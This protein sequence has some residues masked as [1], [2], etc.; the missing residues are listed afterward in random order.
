MK[1]L[2]IHKKILIYLNP[3]INLRC[4]AVFENGKF[5][6][7][8]SAV[9]NSNGNNQVLSFGPDVLKAI[10]TLPPASVNTT[11]T[12]TK[13]SFISEHLRNENAESWIDRNEDRIVPPGFT[14]DQII[15]EWDI[16]HDSIYSATV[17]KEA[18]E[19]YRK[20][21]SNSRLMFNS[22]TIPLWDL[23]ILYSSY[24]RSSFV[25][26][27]VTED[28]SILGYIRDGKLQKLAHFWTDYQDLHKEP[29]E[30]GEELSLLI[31]SLTEGDTIS[32]VIPLII[33]EKPTLPNEFIIPEYIIS[34]PPNINTIPLQYHEPYACSLHTQTQLDFANITDTQK[35]QKVEKNRRKY[36]T[37][38]RGSFIIIVTFVLLLLIS[39]G[40]ITGIEKYADKRIRPYQ[41][42][43]D[44]IEAGERKL[45]SL[46]RTYK[47][48]AIFFTRESI[49]TFLLN[50]LQ[51]IFPDGVWA[52]QI[53]ISEN[54]EKLWRVNI[55]A[56]SY[57]TA[58][59]PQFLNKLEQIEGTDKVRM[60][61]SEQI[62]TE[63]NKRA[64]KI[65]VECLW[66]LGG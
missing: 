33:H 66:K 59:I 17:T 5:N 16:H 1:K 29:K 38:L 14:P 47:E 35:T 34:D 12:N 26:W 42:Y 52:D 43:I 19:E 62:K 51:L 64:I 46:K 60:I 8:V 44:K 56:Q 39:M 45:R 58:L 22:I 41:K 28:N 37:V 54:D 20:I 4:G 31:R 23:A 25:I 53:E 18:F 40:V 32:S 10:I 30:I 57:S 6:F 7:V 63:K 13:I 3:K 36:L 55:I 65:K 61:Y 15:N 24:V 9:D 48:K 11:F 2:P 21:T 50:E 27:K 49:V